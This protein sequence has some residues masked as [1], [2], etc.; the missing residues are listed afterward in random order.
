MSITKKKALRSKDDIIFDAIVLVILAILVLCFL[1]PFFN[2]I[3]MSISNQYA[4]IRGDVSFWPVGFSLASY[5][6]LLH[7]QVVQLSY[8]NTIIISIAGCLLSLLMTSIAAY[9]LAFSDFGLKKVY[10]VF[11]MFTMWFSGGMVPTFIVM[12]QYGLVDNLWVLILN[13][14]ISAYHVLV[15][16]SFYASLPKELIESARIDG[17]NDPIILFKIVIPLSKAALAT[18]AL[19]VLVLHWNDYLNALIYMR[20]TKNYTLQLVLRELVIS[21][22]TSSM[23]DVGNLDSSAISDQLKNAVV[24]VVMA[25]MIIIYPFFQRYFVKG[26]MIGAVK[27]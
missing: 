17:A 4:I 16:K 13:S 3:S 27:G 9:P 26:V 15:L 10:S 14:L 7:T 5:E 21:S 22:Q 23:F 25:P 19:W 11:I 8:R 20:S 12:S 2:I 1:L 18:I 6:K 24:V